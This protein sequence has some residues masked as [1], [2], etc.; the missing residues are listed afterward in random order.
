M[1][2]NV[3]PILPRGNRPRLLRKVVKADR[4]GRAK[5][6]RDYRLR[7]S[8]ERI[9]AQKPRPC[10]SKG[11]CVSPLRQINTGTDYVVITG[12][13]VKRM[14]KH[15]VPVAVAYHIDETCLPK[16]LHPMIR[17]FKQR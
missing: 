11:S 3:I 7:V 4:R 16:E 8:G 17:F 13:E 5:V 1:S 10:A 6:V 14:G 15:L 12:P 9:M 2:S